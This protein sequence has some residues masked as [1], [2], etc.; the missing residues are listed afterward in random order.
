MNARDVDAVTA[1]MAVVRR[2]LSR[3]GGTPEPYLLRDLA[4]G[5]V[6]WIVHRQAVLYAREYG[7]DQTYEALVA[8][9]LS[10]YI[11]SYDESRERG[12]IAERDGQ[13]V[14][15]VFLMIKRATT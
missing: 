13:V 9:I 2:I 15:S 5:D 1:A 3:I 8:E 14:G 12:W 11:K 4:P 6:G 7:W 10:A